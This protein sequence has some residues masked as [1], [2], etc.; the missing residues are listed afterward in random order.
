MQM[1]RFRKATCIH[2]ARPFLAH[3]PEAAEAKLPL[4]SPQL[5][6]PRIQYFNF[7]MEIQIL[8]RQA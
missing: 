1:T 6:E 5:L 2:N 3:L 8:I 7:F 4:Y